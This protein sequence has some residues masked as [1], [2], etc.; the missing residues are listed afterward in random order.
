MVSL[1]WYFVFECKATHLRR[2][3]KICNPHNQK[4]APV[5]NFSAPCIW[6]TLPPN[7]GTRIYKLSS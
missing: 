6:A 2:C 4:V 1:K 5:S 7:M 3:R